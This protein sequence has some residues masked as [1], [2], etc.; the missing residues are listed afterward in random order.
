LNGGLRDLNGW[1]LYVQVPLI[2]ETVE[3]IKSLGGSVIRPKTAVPRAASVTILADP[4]KSIF[5]V[6]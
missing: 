6:W 2:D 4:Q 3:P 5:G 1:L